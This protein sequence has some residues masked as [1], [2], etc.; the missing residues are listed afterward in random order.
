MKKQNKT[1]NRGDINHLWAEFHNLTFNQA[2]EWAFKQNMLNEGYPEAIIW[3]NLL[4]EENVETHLSKDNFIVQIWKN[5]DVRI[6][7]FNT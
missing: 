4:T 5:M 6:Y 7:D 1:G 2:K 3:Q